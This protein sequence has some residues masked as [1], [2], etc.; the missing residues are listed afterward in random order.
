MSSGI[1]QIT[2]KKFRGATTHT[3]I[4]FQPN[5]PLVLIFGENGTGKSSLID[6]ID[7]VC[8]K[9]AG[10]LLDKSSTDAKK[11]LPAIGCKAKDLEVEL[12]CGAETWLAKH[13]GKEIVVTGAAPAPTALILRRARLLRLVEAQPAKQYDEL[14]SFID[15]TNVEASEETLGQAVNEAKGRLNS[16]VQ[17]KSEADGALNQLWQAEREPHSPHAS[18]LAWAQAKAAADIAHLQTEDDEITQ[19]LQLCEHS[20]IQQNDVRSAEKNSEA[21]KE[22]LAAVETDVQTQVQTGAAFNLQ[23]VVLLRQANDYLAAQQ[24]AAECPVCRSTIDLTT[25]RAEL[26]AR[27]VEMRQPDNL[28]KRLT[29]AKALTQNA[30]AVADEAKRQYAAAVRPLAQALQSSAL[31]HVKTAALAWDNLAQLLK[32]ASEAAPAKVQQAE[33]LLAVAQADQLL[34]GLTEL[35]Q[36]L[37]ERQTQLRKDLAQHNAIKQ[38]YDRV[39]AADALCQEEEALL[40]RLQLAYQLVHETRIAFT[41]R[42]LD[43]VKDECRRLYGRIHPGEPYELSALKLDEK[44]K[45]SL[46][47]VASFEG[48]TDV[49]PQAYFSESHLDTL[50]FCFWLAVSRLSSQGDAIIVLDD[51]FTSA[52]N[53]H[54]ARIADLL[55]EECANFRQ[56]IITSHN[57]RWR[58]LYDYRKLPENKTCLVQLLPWKRAGGIRHHEAKL[59]TG[60]LRELLAAP[61]LD[62]QAVPSKAGVLL[63]GLFDVLVIQYRCS[64]QRSLQ[65]TLQDYCNGVKKL[66]AKL[67]VQHLA[68][69]EE[70]AES[71]EEFALQPLLADISEHYYVRNLLGGHAN[72]AGEEIP[73]HEARR[74]GELAVELI[75]RLTCRACGEIARKLHSDHYACRCG[76]L[77]MEPH[78]LS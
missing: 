61:V 52:D 51:V 20:A 77:K 55:V 58:T 2:L 22:A 60:E 62:R 16:Y 78:K 66:A 37:V 3:T 72:P 18:E 65:Y 76:K 64:M 46:H 34:T 50:G 35:R 70:S 25:L 14:R 7:F 4:D 57:R 32:A 27:L 31:L 53:V 42:I 23:L 44:R 41:N 10:S 26:A 30:E 1:T 19:L 75:E 56:I 29:E 54:L 12:T 39:L 74:F 24:E 71:W 69:D 73:D 13:T 45:G 68:V 15:V 40:H 48:F 5:K 9:Y 33:L 59:L 47:Q 28:S 63:E 11:H 43:D 49:A 21:Q 38:A 8:N 67:K 6:A 36:Q 17:Q